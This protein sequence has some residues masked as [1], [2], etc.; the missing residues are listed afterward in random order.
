MNKKISGKTEEIYKF[1]KNKVKENNYPPTLREIAIEV[2]LNS[3]WTVRYHLK[4]LSDYGYIKLK[5]GVSRGI[6]IFNLNTGIPILGRISAG[7]PEEAIENVENY[8]SDL[9]DFFGMFDIF[10]LKVKGDSME[11]EGIKDNDIVIVKKQP[12]AN[13]GDIV[14]AMIDGE[15]TVKFFYHT[16]KGIK[17]VPAN[18]AY[19]PIV[20]KNVKILGKV[21][22]V[23]R[24]Y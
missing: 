18:P 6:E 1:I 23:I 17:L 15:V 8:I 22:G 21:T 12:V 2:G 13:N 11:G 4:K 10:A 24:K 5:K 14:A 7:R 16:Q 3:T 20:S 9:T 19:K